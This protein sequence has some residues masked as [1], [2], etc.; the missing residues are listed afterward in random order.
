MLSCQ[1]PIQTSVQNF[2][3]QLSN[4]SPPSTTTV[5]TFRVN[6]NNLW[7]CVNQLFLFTK[8]F[9]FF[10]L[11]SF[12][13]NIKSKVF[14]FPIEPKT[15]SRS[16]ILKKNSNKNCFWI[17]KMSVVF[18]FLLAFPRI[19]MNN[20]KNCTIYN[21][22]VSDSDCCTAKPYSKHTAYSTADRSKS[23]CISRNNAYKYHSVSWH[24]RDTKVIWKIWLNVKTL[25]GLLKL[26]TKFLKLRP[27]SFEE[28]S[29]HKECA[30]DASLPK[31]L[32]I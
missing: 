10:L 32:Q 15:E 16:S 2:S 29:T 20:C 5:Q 14:R 26:M 8:Y 17:M 1:K 27:I 22:S 19:L 25:M 23:S 31:G 13:P 12:Q 4:C 21:V 28:K 6:T 9:T 7:M 24:L 11:T 3:C 30:K 18:K